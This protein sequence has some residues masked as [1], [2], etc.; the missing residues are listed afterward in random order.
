MYSDSRSFVETNRNTWRIMFSKQGRQSGL[1]EL[2][3]KTLQEISEADGRIN[4]C[5]TH[6]GRVIEY[7]MHCVGGVIECC[8]HCDVR[9]LMT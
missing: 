8:M 2:N 1:C 5:K 3:N 7:R 6:R 4:R 9:Q